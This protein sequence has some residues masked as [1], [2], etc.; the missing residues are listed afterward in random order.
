[1]ITPGT[2]E[3]LAINIAI[4]LSLRSCMPRVII[5]R[6]FDACFTHEGHSVATQEINRDIFADGESGAPRANGWA[7]SPGLWGGTSEVR[8]RCIPDG[9]K[10]GVRPE[11]LPR[12]RSLSQFGDRA[13]CNQLVARAPLPPEEVQDA[14]DFV[15]GQYCAPGGHEPIVCISFYLKRSAQSIQEDRDQRFIAP[16]QPL[17]VP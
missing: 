7:S 9:M 14:G 1:M 13:G 5:P 16:S 8:L 11:G 10:L 4:F 12:V 6:I 15:I 17:R 3:S 2:F